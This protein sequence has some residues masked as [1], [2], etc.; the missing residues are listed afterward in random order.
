MGYVDDIRS[1]VGRRP[2][3]LA[4]AGV[5]VRDNQ[6]RVLLQRRGDDGLWATP[7]GAKE[8]GEALEE[9]ARREVMEE[10]G[11]NVGSLRL[12]EV[13]SGPSMRYT[14]PN[15]DE[16]DIV[17]HMYETNDYTGEL[18]SDRDESLDLRFFE[19]AELETLPL[20]AVNRPLIRAFLRAN[21]LSG[22]LADDA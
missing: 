18:Q 15:G 4:A 10:T 21:G 7:G 14:Y 2:L 11:L 5:F 16:V 19:L 22:R 8:L 20:N 17:S 6:G 13:F 3:I 12:F 9:T 1:F